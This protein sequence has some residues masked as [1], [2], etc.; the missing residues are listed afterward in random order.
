MVGILS[1]KNMNS[2]HCGGGAHSLERQGTE[3]WL[4]VQNGEKDGSWEALGPRLG[5][6][7][8]YDLT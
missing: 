4:K 6:F 3:T 1:F 7:S 5:S 2:A 8:G